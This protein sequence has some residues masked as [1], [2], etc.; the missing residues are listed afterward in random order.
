MPI[1]IMSP[2]GQILIPEEIKRKLKLEPGQK[3][4]MEIMSDGC[5][6]ITPIPKDVIS[7][8]ELPEAEKLEKTHAN[9]E[10]KGEVKTNE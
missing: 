7:K 6:L 10:I 5:I 2:E 8:M 3:F 9:E 1:T 4:E